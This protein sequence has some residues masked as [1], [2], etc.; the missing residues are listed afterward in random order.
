[1]KRNILFFLT[2]SMMLVSS[3]APMRYSRGD[4]NQDGMVSIKD[5]TT[6]INYLLNGTWP[7]GGD[8]EQSGDTKR[9]DV[10]NDDVVNIKDV[11]TLI[12][13]LLNGSWPV[14]DAALQDETFTVN[15]ISF[16]MVGVQGGTYMMGGTDEQGTD[17]SSLE[18]PVHE[19]TLSDY[20]IGQTE[21]TQALWA[22][23]MGTNPSYFTSAKGYGD[24]VNRPVESVTW[25]DCNN[26][27]ARL[28]ELTGRQFRMPTEAEWQYAARGGNKTQGHKYAG[29]DV[30][31]DVAWYRVNSFDQGNKSPDYG[32]HA[33]A[34]KAPNEL[35][36]YDMSGNVNEWCSDWYGSYTEDA[37]NNPS[38]P[39]TGTS[40]MCPGGS[41][42]SQAAYCRV[43]YRARYAPTMKSNIIGLR[44]VMI[45]ER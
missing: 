24:N 8:G 33:V 21:V 42:G 18:K 17:A 19:V 27:I 20:Y 31:D 43:S 23:V 6:L 2:A 41:W 36:L 3:A 13:Y 44:L 40:R 14:N 11:T 35:G 10:S 29:G 12:H 26:F 15:G 1:M 4:V 34:T 5:V 25:D 37:Q 22:A 28:S 30:I 9:G 32:T 39:E 16:T 7:D 38:G 45:P